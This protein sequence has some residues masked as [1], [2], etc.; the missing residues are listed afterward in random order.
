MPRITA[1]ERVGKA[2]SAFKWGMSVRHEEKL[3][4]RA[5]GKFFI[6]LVDPST[7]EVLEHRECN[8]VITLDAGI[9]AAT[10]FKD[11]QTPLPGVNNGLKMLGVGTGATG[12]ILSPDAPQPTQRRLNAEIQRKPFSSTQYRDGNGIAVAYRT[13]IVDFTTTYT[14]A[15]AVGPLTEMALMSTASA[16]PAETNPIMNGPTNYDP[17]ID[18]DGFD[19]L[20][21]YLTFAVISKPATAILSITWRLIF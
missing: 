13:N 16:N 12:N 15:E 9:L 3:T 18:V 5:E 2:R 1:R 6:D 17:T 14:E 10:L 19:L 8:N 20:A 7:G 11:S 21:N 4:E